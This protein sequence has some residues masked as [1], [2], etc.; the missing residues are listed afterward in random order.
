MNKRPLLDFGKNKLEK[1][2]PVAEID[3]LMNQ[4]FEETYHNFVN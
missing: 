1:Y 4:R 3:K 2:I